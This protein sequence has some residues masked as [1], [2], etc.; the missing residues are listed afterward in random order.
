MTSLLKKTYTLRDAAS[1]REPREFTQ[2]MLRTAR[3][4]GINNPS[5]QLDMIYTNINL[6]LQIFLQRPTESTSINSFL[7]ELNNRKY[8]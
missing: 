5:P 8:E 7:T 1:K 3:D 2:R 4:T 6:A